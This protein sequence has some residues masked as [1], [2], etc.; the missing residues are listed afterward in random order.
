MQEGEVVD[1]CDYWTGRTPGR[2]EPAAHLKRGCSGFWTGFGWLDLPGLTELR[3]PQ[4]AAVVLG[5]V[6]F[7]NTLAD[8]CGV[9]LL[10]GD[11]AMEK[12]G[13]LEE[14]S[15]R[16]APGAGEKPTPRRTCCLLSGFQA[17][18]SSEGW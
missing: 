6:T 1:G 4:R 9:E 3:S 5:L 16:P 12:A 10:E 17:M 11:G 2:K 7:C 13:R 8:E 15:G 18:D 14:P